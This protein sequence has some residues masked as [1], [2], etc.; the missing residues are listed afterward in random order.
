MENASDK[1]DRTCLKCSIDGSKKKMWKK[2]EHCK[3]YGKQ[4]RIVY[5]KNARKPSEKQLFQ[6]QANFQCLKWV[7]GT[8]RSVREIYYDKSTSNNINGV[9]YC[10]SIGISKQTSRIKYAWRLF[11][12]T[13]YKWLYRWDPLSCAIKETEILNS[14]SFIRPGL[15][16]ISFS[17]FRLLALLRKPICVFHLCTFIYIYWHLYSL[18]CLL[19]SHPQCRWQHCF[20]NNIESEW[21]WGKKWNRMERSATRNCRTNICI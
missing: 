6:Q 7:F 11:P 16:A 18:F 1:I 12:T 10:K 8:E 4:K 15:L 3:T 13:P 5:C 2:W 17:L 14:N 21:L 20:N 9:R 19:L